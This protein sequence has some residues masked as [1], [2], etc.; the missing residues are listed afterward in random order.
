MEQT[1]RISTLALAGM[2]VVAPAVLEL[3]CRE[4]AE[5]DFYARVSCETLGKWFRSPYR[6]S[7][8]SLVE[9]TF[10]PH[11]H[12]ENTDNDDRAPLTTVG[13]FASGNSTN[14]TARAVSAIYATPGLMEENGGKPGQITEPERFDS[15][16]EAM[17]APFPTGCNFALIRGEEGCYV[18]HSSRFGWEP[19]PP[20]T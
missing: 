9:R 10:P 5:H 2:I 12:S 1:K 16:E 6:E 7:C 14:G 20:K 13:I 4:M 19:V 18:Y 3:S 15:V 8:D 17:N 11:N